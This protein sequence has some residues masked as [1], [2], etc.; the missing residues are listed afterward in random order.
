MQTSQEVTIKDIQT[1]Q[2]GTC[3]PPTMPSNG[4]LVGTAK[5]SYRIG[6][7]VQVKC[8]LFSTTANSEIVCTTS[9]WT[10]LTR[11]CTDCPT[12]WVVY[13]DR[14]F[15]YL[16]SGNFY[17]T[18]INNCQ[19]QGSS[20]TLFQVR[21]SVDQQTLR[22]YKILGGSIAYP[23]NWISGKLESANGRWLFS[24]TNTQMT[25]T[26]WSS[27]TVLGDMNY[28]CIQLLA[29][30]DANSPGAWNTSD[31]EGTSLARPMCQLDRNGLCSDNYD[32]CEQVMTSYPQFCTG[33]Q[34]AAFGDI[35]CSR[36]CGECT[37][38]PNC[39]APTSSVYT[40]TSALAS[41]APGNFM[42]F[43][44][45]AGLYYVSGDKQRACSSTGNLLGTELVCQAQPVATDVNLN[46]VIRRSNTLTTKLVVVMDRTGSRIPFNGNISIWYYYCITP[47]AVSFL[48]YRKNGTSYNYVGANNITCQADFKWAYTVPAESQIAVQANDVIGVYSTAATIATSDC[49][50]AMDK[51]CNFPSVTANNWSEVQTKALNVTS[52][53]C[54]SLG[55]RVI[56]V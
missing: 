45:N 21:D 32:K 54:P 24:T 11:A 30:N 18:A 12:G 40:R 35:Y 55:V 23:T 52:C 5:S 37:G 34:T 31:C 20:G 2:Q 16:G 48:V 25:Y 51:I 38:L 28:D 26:N 13:G 36:S 9:G 49:T 22:D 29:E 33:S 14:C 53:R 39:T 42:S 47:G 10:N 6:E 50:S 4:V 43:D 17:S 19:S 41:I 56:P 7:R 46:S 44:C 8:T 3:D 1:T 15:K 27:T